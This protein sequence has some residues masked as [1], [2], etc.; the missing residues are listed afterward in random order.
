MIYLIEL[1][2]CIFAV[3]RAS[4]RLEK[5][6]GKTGKIA[7][8]AK[9]RLKYMHLMKRCQWIVP[10]YSIKPEQYKSVAFSRKD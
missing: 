8:V 3:G 6:K 7:V 2:H 1:Y 10:V 9:L 4:I 5:V